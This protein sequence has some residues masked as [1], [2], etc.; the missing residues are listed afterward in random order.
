MAHRA[1]LAVHACDDAVPAPAEEVRV[2]LGRL[3]EV[4]GDAA[5]FKAIKFFCFLGHYEIADLANHLRLG[6]FQKRGMARETG[7]G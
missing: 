5:D 2:A 6:I 4:T 3:L 1:A 7:H